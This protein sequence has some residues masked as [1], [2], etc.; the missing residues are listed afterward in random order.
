MA[1]V[2]RL[3]RDYALSFARFWNILC[4]NR[5]NTRNGLSTARIFIDRTRRTQMPLSISI[6]SIPNP[7][8][9]GLDVTLRSY[10]SRIRQIRINLGVHQLQQLTSLSELNCVKHFDVQES[11]VFPH[12]LSDVKLSHPALSLPQSIQFLRVPYPIVT[13][14]DY[15]MSRLTHF[16]TSHLSFDG[17]ASIF[18]RAP[19][20]LSCSAKITQ[21]IPLLPGP[22]TLTHGCLKELR[23]QFQIDHQTIDLTG[24]PTLYRLFFESWRS[25]NSCLVNENNSAL[26]E[27]GIHRTNV[28][29]VYRIITSA[30]SLRRLIVN[31]VDFQHL[32]KHDDLINFIMTHFEQI[33]IRIV[34]QVGDLHSPSVHFESRIAEIL[35]H[36]AYFPGSSHKFPQID[37]HFPFWKPIPT[38]PSW[39]EIGF[40][41][42]AEKG[43]KVT[44]NKEAVELLLIP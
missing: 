40:L 2:C 27:L 24:I 39:F 33:T 38:S 42:T 31:T 20:L 22:P 16:Y 43:F 28:L 26:T 18:A 35:D 32:F 9:K 25:P 19:A 15:D 21:P 37:I 1:S 4:L 12:T 3:W 13:W 6:H 34:W 14:D 23:L 30:P 44:V 17:L 10:H 29:Q 11:V 5:R 7:Y 8:L 36:L 41:K